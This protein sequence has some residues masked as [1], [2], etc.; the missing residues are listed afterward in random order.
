ML[1]MWSGKKIAPILRCTD[2]N[3]GKVTPQGVPKKSR[4]GD[5]DMGLLVQGNIR[6]PEANLYVTAVFLVNQSLNPAQVH[7]SKIGY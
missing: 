7:R 4:A 1:M 6:L 5:Q 2:F 3:Y